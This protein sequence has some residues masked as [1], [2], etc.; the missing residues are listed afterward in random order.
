MPRAT[1]RR[2]IFSSFHRVTLRAMRRSEPFMFSIA[3]V[4]AKVRLSVAGRVTRTVRETT[5][6][7]QKVVAGRWDPAPMALRVVA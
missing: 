3:F 2:I 4:V 6:K 5:S 7:K 1:H